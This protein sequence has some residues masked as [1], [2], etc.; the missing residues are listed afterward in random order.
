MKFKI[1]NMIFSDAINNVIRALSTKTPMPILK[2][3]KLDLVNEGIY[4]TASD[5]NIT[6]KQFVPTFINDKQILYIEEI[7]NAAIPGRLLQDVL[8]KVNEEFVEIA[9]YEDKF[10]KINFKNSDYTL[11]CLDVREYPNIN[12]ISSN[13]PIK[14]E[15]NKLVELIR[16]TV[17][18][19]ST[20]ESRPI[21][22]GVNLKIVNNTMYC[23][24]T[25]S[26][27]LS[28]KVLNLDYELPNINIVIPGKSLIE[29]EKIIT[30]S[31]GL[32]DIHLTNNIISFKLD[33]IIFQSRL[34]DG[35]YP[36]TSRLIPKDFGLIQEFNRLELI[37]VIDRVSLLS[38][39]GASNIIK[40]D[41]YEDKTIISLDSPEIGKVVEEIVPKKQEGSLIRIGFNSKFL[42]DALRV[43]NQENILVKFTGEVRPFI[44]K[45]DDDSV[46]QLI[47]PVRIE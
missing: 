16:Q 47:L 11:N 13:S 27:R 36:E 25:D 23:I 46:T 42:L 18:S 29:F 32:V 44:I 40:F 7:G 4:L 3:I 8:R 6:I 21:L 20:N 35:T 17:I 19:I 1:Q 39:E 10:I 5:S 34:L 45:T 31:N 26:Y 15:V 2:S 38:K 24:S 12:L 37:E 41:I 22:T 14:I 43:L 33:N 9:L 30:N 28:Q